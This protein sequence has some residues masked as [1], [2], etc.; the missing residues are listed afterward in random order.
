MPAER[1]VQ[2]DSGTAGGNQE[3]TAAGPGYNQ[4]GQRHLQHPCVVSSVSFVSGYDWSPTH[5]RLN[6]LFGMAN[7]CPTDQRVVSC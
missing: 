3:T 5:F 2:S 6:L 7:A 4:T 1:R